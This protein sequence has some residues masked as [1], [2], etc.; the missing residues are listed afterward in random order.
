MTLVG[1]R[2]LSRGLLFY[3][4]FSFLFLFFFIVTAKLLSRPGSGNKIHNGLFLWSLF[5]GFNEAGH[6]CTHAGSSVGIP[7]H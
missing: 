4:W 1:Y 5:F 3:S 6:G 2:A 7:R